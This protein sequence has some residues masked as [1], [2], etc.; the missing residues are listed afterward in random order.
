[1]DSIFIDAFISLISGIPDMRLP[2][3]KKLG[4]WEVSVS[5]FRVSSYR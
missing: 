1:M 2:K 4:P 3:R 5:S